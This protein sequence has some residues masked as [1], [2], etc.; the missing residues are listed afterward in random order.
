MIAGEFI[1]HIIHIGFFIAFYLTVKGD[2][3]QNKIM[4]SMSD[5]LGAQYQHS[6][7][8]EDRINEL[9]MA[10]EDRHDNNNSV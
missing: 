10:P 9:E 1:D 3:A 2:A 5:T 4:E 7:E 8:L 6:V